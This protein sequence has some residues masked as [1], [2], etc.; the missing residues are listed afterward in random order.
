MGSLALLP[1]VGKP[2]VPPLRFAPVGACDF[3]IFRCSLR[4]ESS[5]EHL[6][7]SIAGVLRLR[8]IKPSVCDRS[9]K[10]F[11]QD[12]GFVGGLKYSWLDMQKTRKIEKVTGSRDDK[13][14]SSVSSRDCLLGKETAGPSTT[15]RSGRD[16]KGESSVSSTGLFAGKGNC[17]SLGYADS[18]TAR[19]YDWFSTAPTA[20]GSSSGSI[21]RWTGL[22]PVLMLTP[23]D[24][25]LLAKSA[26]AI[27]GLC[28]SFSAH[29]R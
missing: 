7:T 15:L 19:A 25:G 1:P 18:D 10:R 13:G 21:S 23:S 28:P 9:A 29:V 4:P 20:L 2:Q 24:M 8:A 5:Q 16:D 12:D 26:K 14:E 22:D 17:R 3:F 11:A 27:V 6:P